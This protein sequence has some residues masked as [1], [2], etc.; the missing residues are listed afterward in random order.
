MMCTECKVSMSV[1]MRR[2]S[3]GRITGYRCPRCKRIR[4][5][6]DQPPTYTQR[7]KPEFENPD[8]GP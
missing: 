7:L 4:S 8:E 3:T 2:A 5:I 1:W 6:Y